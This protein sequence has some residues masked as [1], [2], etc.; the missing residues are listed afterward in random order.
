MG[1]I[2]ALSRCISNTVGQRAA[3]FAVKAIQYVMGIGSGSRVGISGE[4]ASITRCKDNPI[5]F[6]VGANVG[7]FAELVRGKLKDFRLYCFEPGIEAYKALE[8]NLND[9]RIKVFNF[10]LGSEDGYKILHYDE[11]G[12]GMASLT[13]RR[14]EHFGIELDKSEPVKIKTLDMVC[15]ELGISHVDLL[16]IDVEGHE[17]DVLKGASDLFSRKA[18]D[19]VQFEFGGCNIDTRTYFQ[20]FFYFFKDQGM[21]IHRVTPSGYLHP[22]KKYSE[23]DEQ[24]RTTNYLVVFEAP[25]Q[26]GPI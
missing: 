24:F 1:L 22:I 13:K 19:S 11:A 20:D 18:I 17:L 25:R 10:A 15:R 8:R 3:G 4:I 12:S 16:K 23:M 14:L 21:T 5:I 2:T 26:A 9:E 6:D 7:Q